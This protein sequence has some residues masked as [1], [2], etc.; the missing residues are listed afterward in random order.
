MGLYRLAE[1]K[2]FYCSGS[3][4]W[5]LVLA[6]LSAA[7]L[8]FLSRNHSFI[9]M[10][11]EGAA[12][13]FQTQL[14]MFGFDKQ[15]PSC[16]LHIGAVSLPLSLNSYTGP[17]WF[18]VYAPTAYLW[19]EKLSTDPY[20]YRY[21][22]IVFFL[23]NV[24]VLYYLLRQYYNPSISFYSAAAFLTS[25]LLLLGCLTEHGITN[26]MLLFILITAFLFSHYIKGGSVAF[27]LGSGMALGMT[28]LTRVEAFVWLIIPFLIYL[29]LARPPEVLDRWRQ[30]KRKQ[31]VALFVIALFCL[32]ASPV[33]AYNLICSDSNIFSFTANTVLPR[34]L[35]ASSLSLWGGLGGRI[36]QFWNYNLLNIG[37]MWELHVA[38]YLMAALWIVSAGI[39]AVRWIARRHPSLILVMVLTALAL[40]ILTTGGQRNEHLMIIEPAALLVI[41][42]A[43]AYVERLRSTAKLAHIAFI[44]LI[45][46]N[47]VVAA[48]DWQGWNQLTSS[49]QTMLNQSDPVLLA[50]YLSEH[51]AADRILYTNVGMSQYVLYMTAGQLKGED[52]MDWTSINGFIKAVKL[53]LLDKS[54]RRVFVAV[55]RDHDGVGGAAARTG[56]LYSVLDQY[57]V[58]YEITHLSNERNHSLYDLIVVNDGVTLAGDSS[59]AET[60]LVSDVVDVRVVVQPTGESA[61]F[62]SILGAGFKPGDAV[63]INGKLILPST[64]GNAAWITFSIPPDALDNQSSFTLEV[65]RAESLERSKTLTVRIRQ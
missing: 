26:I 2:R 37:P 19:F 57:N 6:L 52:I 53:T 48:M 63:N 18:Y 25:P 50:S 43:L 23:T 59:M 17:A 61:V 28:L 42:S 24:W 47:L 44:V 20:I 56:T 1:A 30:T 39:I 31:G 49:S 45:A 27:L 46:G 64:Y 41:T 60:I 16:W 3:R 10:W 62:G 34:S 11:S 65:I 4:K 8:W 9:P 38:N 51:H 32:G 22:S 58:P 35:G 29:V 55:S 7:A 54:K 13:C 12:E 14:E 36:E 5:T 33:I 21:T 40:S 15:R